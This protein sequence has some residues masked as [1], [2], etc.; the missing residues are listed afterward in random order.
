MERPRGACVRAFVRAC[1][2]V[3]W[4]RLRVPLSSPPLQD[5]RRTSTRYSP[6][7]IETRFLWSASSSDVQGSLRLWVDIMPLEDASAYP[8]ID[9][10]PTPPAPYEVRAIVWKTR[11]IPSGDLLTHMSGERRGDHREG[12]LAAPPCRFL[13]PRSPPDLYVRA[14]LQEGG[15][16]RDIVRATDTHWRCQGGNGSF[17]YRMKCVRAGMPG[18]TFPAPIAYY[19]SLQVG[20]RA[21]AQ[22]LP[23]A[24]AGVGPGSVQ[25][26]A[27]A[28]AGGSSC[29]LYWLSRRLRLPLPL[30]LPLRSTT[31]AWAR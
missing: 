8:L 31:T 9:I 28:V 19:G 2:A 7:P 4:P 24:A 16:G 21:A 18:A 23:A 14:A 25:G 11:G 30:P 22:D 27:V 6:K 17:N 12:R 20:R 15:V 29:V 26:E 5:E 3:A 13:P 1:S 10:S